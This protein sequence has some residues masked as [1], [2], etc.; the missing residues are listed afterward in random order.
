M[1]IPPV[2]SSSAAT[3]IPQVQTKKEPDG[4]TKAQEAAESTKVK[5][6][7]KLNSGYAPKATPPASSTQN[8]GVVTSTTSATNSGT[9]KL[10]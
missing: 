7:E 9:N 8:T 2:G 6:A 5:Q 10:V 3:A 4:D 1:S